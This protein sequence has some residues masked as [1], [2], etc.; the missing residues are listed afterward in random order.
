MTYSIE[1][2]ENETISILEKKMTSDHQF[3]LQYNTM[4][5]YFSRKLLNFINKESLDP[6]VQE[7]EDVVQAQYF[8][9]YH[10]MRMLLQDEFFTEDERIWTGLEGVTRQQIPALLE[11]VFLSSDA[12]EWDYTPVA[13]NFAMKLLKSIT[14][15]YDLFKVARKE[16]A[17]IGAIQAFMDDPRYIEREQVPN[18][19]LSYFGPIDDHIFLTPEIYMTVSHFQEGRQVWNVY[20]WGPFNNDDWMGTVEFHELSTTEGTLY[21]LN[22]MLS[23]L[24]RADEHYDIATKLYSDLPEDVQLNLQIKHFTCSDMETLTK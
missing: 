3:I 19:L 9:G 1:H 2:L 21:G 10:V 24:I 18:E 20:G 14:N 17:Y 23:S 6:L 4:V 22:L 8:K 12:K 15:I 7:F 13:H 16:I 11:E 5:E